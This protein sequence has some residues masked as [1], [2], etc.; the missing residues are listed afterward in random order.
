MKYPN[1]FSPIKI[2]GLELKNRIDFPGMGVFFT[3]NGGYVND[4]FI[5]YHVARALGGTALITPEATSVH[6]P[7]APSN[8][9]NISDD[10]FLPGLK[11]FT[12]AVHEA[13]AKVCVQL[14]QGGILPVF[15]DPNTIAVIPSE[16]TLDMAFGAALPQPM[17]LP[18]TTKEMIV[19]VEKA[20]GSAAKR[21]VEAGFDTLEFHLAHG[22]SPH[23]FLSPAYNHR[24]DEYGGSFENR[25][26][27]PLECIREIRRNMPDDMPLIMR[28]DA[29]D[30]YLENGLTI[31]DVIAFCKLA[32]A[33]GVDA[34]NVSRGNPTTFGMKFEVPP[35]DLPKGFNVENAA[36][37]KRETGLVT[38]A[39]GRINDPDQAEAIIAE[40]KADMVVM[41]RAQL[42][43]PEFCNKAAAGNDEDIVRCVGC[44]QGC[45]GSEGG[46]VTCTR[47]PAVGREAEYVLKA[48]DHP[49]KVV[50]IGG[51]MGGLETAITLKQRGHKVV[52]LEES[53][54][55]GGQFYIAGLAPGKAEMKDAAV[56]RG[57]QA[58]KAG[59][60]I[61]LSTQA[62]PEILDSL[63]P[64]MIVIA[65]GA[66]PIELKIP[67]ADLPNVVNS[68]DV[69]EGRVV[70]KG[71]VSVIGGGL[72]GL[73]VAEFVV[74][75]DNNNEMTVI[76]ML[77]GVG[78][79]LASARK[80]CTVE[81][82]AENGVHIILS[83]K[84]VEITKDAVII[85]KNG[86]T[87]AVASDYIVISVGSIANDIGVLT[88]YCK[89]KGIPYHV[90]GDAKK[91]RKV[92]D[93][94]A[95]GA[96]IARAI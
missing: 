59:I 27:Y 13:G 64:D 10:K 3:D 88:N 31:E 5:S 78:K 50:V 23:A 8:F 53:N 89:D 82:I 40:G 85:D 12:A 9:L 47:N 87:E 51:G 17:T 67:G 92:I 42:A 76:E 68:F 4:R 83:A 28:I 74:E 93:A 18:G 19:E 15:F 75:M 6:A 81:R 45:G 7:S 91:A 52:L 96:E 66:H 48:T 16:I 20:F 25:S 2:R 94:I 62:T 70:P 49:Q 77:D 24:T 33:E 30:D 61:R 43:D 39:V 29:H 37:I 60:D 32:K 14:W 26:R 58:K 65:S 22:Y 79:D 57:L 56:S 86:T 80:L 38:I 46:D 84:C 41:G 11:K 72:V 55:L 21:A 1:L 34:V 95:E 73:E 35:I 71:K 44:N 63:H 36:R 54:R 90:I 69:L